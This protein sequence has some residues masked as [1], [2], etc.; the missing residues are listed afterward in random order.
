[1]RIEDQLQHIR[2]VIECSHVARILKRD[3][4]IV[5]IYPYSRI[6]SKSGVFDMLMKE[7]LEPNCSG[8][9]MGEGLR[10]AAVKAMYNEDA[11]GSELYCSNDACEPIKLTRMCKVC[12][13]EEFAQD[14][15]RVCLVV[16]SSWVQPCHS[17]TSIS[18]SRFDLVIPTI[19]TT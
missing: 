18:V 13:I 2:C 6:C 7:V 17:S 19:V 4:R 10:D 9:G 16:R 12:L 1:M 15:G 14:R 5:S 3:I 11:I 8:P